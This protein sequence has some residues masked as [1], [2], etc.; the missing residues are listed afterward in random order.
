MKALKRILHDLNQG[1]ISLDT[2]EALILELFKGNTPMNKDSALKKLK[3]VCTDQTD[4]SYGICVHKMGLDTC[5]F[6][7]GTCVYKHLK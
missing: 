2:S 5:T 4:S 7:S 3:Y 1:N 6:S